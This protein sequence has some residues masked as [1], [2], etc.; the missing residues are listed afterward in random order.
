MDL[1]IHIALFALVSLGIVVM[2]SFYGERDDSRA[3]RAVPRRFLVFL[4]SCAVVA[5]V[6]LVCEHVFASA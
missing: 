2:G 3:L 6:M 5:L 4:A 1:V